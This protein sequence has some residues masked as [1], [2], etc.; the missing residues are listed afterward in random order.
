[1]PWISVHNKLKVRCSLLPVLKSLMT[2]DKV[3]SL[4][5]IRRTILHFNMISIS[6]IARL[7]RKK[8]LH[9]VDMNW[10]VSICS[11]TTSPTNGGLNHTVT[12]EQ[13][14]CPV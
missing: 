8:R 7:W 9:C 13:I 14:Q 2:M 12:Y 5:V 10:E 6:E 4:Q 11:S 3:V 1:M